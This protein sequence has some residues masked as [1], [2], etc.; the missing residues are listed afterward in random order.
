MHTVEHIGLGRYGDE[1]NS[2]ADLLAINELKRVLKENG[3]LYFV[4]PVGVPRVYFN[5]H[6][7]YSY[8]M[9]MDLFS[10]L[11]LINFSLITDKSEFLEN[12]DSD[13]VKDQ[14]YGCGC[15]HF[16]KF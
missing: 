4:V 12:A 11:C 13:V 8:E 9:I 2:D 5:S 14:N 15:F 16:R 1:I 10:D 6:R 3:D 7:V